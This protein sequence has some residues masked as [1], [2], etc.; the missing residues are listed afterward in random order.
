[1]GG[2]IGAGLGPA[3]SALALEHPQADWCV[4]ELSSYQLGAVETL[5]VDIGV[6]TNLAPDHLD[7]YASVEAY[8]A[9]KAGLFNRAD[10]RSRWVLADQPE[11]EALAH[12]VPGARWTVS[13]ERRPARGAFLDGAMLTLALEQGD[14][15]L[16][17]R[18]QLRILGLHNVQNALAAALTAR[19][20][21]ASL[22][23]VRE[24]L[25][26]FRPLPHRL[27]PVADRAGVL[28]IDDS[29]GT[30]VAA[31]ASAI[32]S[33]ERPLVVLLGG[34]DKGESFTPLLAPLQA[35]ARVAIVYGA[36]RDRLERELGADVRV[37]RVDGPFEDVVARARALAQPGDAVLLSP[38]T[39]SFDMFDNYEHR[40][41]RFRALAEEEETRGTA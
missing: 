8:Y 29:K 32:A 38:A 41:R 6:V 22:S 30:N 40:G 34:V 25:V 10:A 13:L 35:R 3:A 36:V 12:G 21:G 4:L 9:D 20:A 28:W 5:K 17:E 16:V 18:G 37:V 2:N 27:E 26:S 11:V 7:R 19:L 24:A 15:P 1:L 14:E 31:A 33:V 39:A 23:H